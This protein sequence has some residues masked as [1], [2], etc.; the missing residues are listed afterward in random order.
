LKT[1]EDFA[2]AVMI[3]TPFGFPMV[4][5]PQKPLPHY[6]KFPGGR[7]IGPETPIETA[8]RQIREEVGITLTAKDLSLVRK[9]S[10]NNDHFFYFYSVKLNQRP[11]L[12]EQGNEG[13]DVCLVPRRA[14][15][16]GREVHPRHLRLALQFMSQ[17]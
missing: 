2:V 16:A 9:M 1:K 8:L 4:R 11:V 13:E 7:S 15:L 6:W 3:E 10:C 5:D 17:R 14:L 12:L